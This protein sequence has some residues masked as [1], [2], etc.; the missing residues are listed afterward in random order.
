MDLMTSAPSAELEA[1]EE[2]FFKIQ[3]R[4][5]KNFGHGATDEALGIAQGCFERLAVAVEARLEEPVVRS[6][7]WDEGVHRL[8][9][10]VSP[11]TL[12]LATLNSALNGAMKES[13]KTPIIVGLGR[14]VNHELFANDLRLHDEALKAKIEKWVSEKHGNLKVRLQAARSVAKKMGFSFVSEWKTPQLS[15]VGNFLIDVLLTALPDLFEQVP[16]GDTYRIEITEGAQK[17]AQAAVKQ[18]VRSNPVFLP[19]LVPPVPWTDFN[20][21]GPVD[22]VAQ[23]LGSL[24]RTHHRETVAAVKAA[25]RSGQMQPAMDALN[26]VQATGWR[27]N[28]YVMNVMKEC[29]RRG[30]AVEGLPSD[31]DFP[32]PSL[33]DG[34]WEKY[35]D[36]QKK[37]WRS[38]KEG[39]KRANRTL[40]ADRLRY[41]E[42]METADVLAEHP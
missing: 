24:V 32:V 7:G 22:P 15:A 9:K 40:K 35:D 25:V 14:T 5:A 26:A 3:E 41:D 27:I 28:T 33:D 20:K 39:I 38:K 12:A 18:F 4:T 11:H 8:L 1:A 42:D 21:G 17:L 37:A 29:K 19:S 6:K 2:R 34:L 36:D 13:T 23:K 30:I 16:V 31:E 10:T